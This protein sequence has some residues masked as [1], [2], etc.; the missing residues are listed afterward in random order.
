MSTATQI[1]PVLLLSALAPMS[2]ERMVKSELR[3]TVD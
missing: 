1:T 3:N 2:I